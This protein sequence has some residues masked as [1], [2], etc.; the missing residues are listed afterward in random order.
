MCTGARRRTQVDLPLERVRRLTMRSSVCGLVI[1]LTMLPTS[2]ISGVWKCV[3]QDGHVYYLNY[4]NSSMTCTA[5]SKD[6]PA[7]QTTRRSSRHAGTS[8]K[9]EAS[10]ESDRAPIP[11][12]KPTAAYGTGFFV[13]DGTYVATNAHVVDRCMRI[14]V[15][16]QNRVGQ[17]DLVAENATDDLAVLRVTGV[18]GVATSIRQHDARSGESIL[19]AG[20]PLAG[21]LSSELGVSDGIVNTTAGLRGDQSR[22][23][24]SAPV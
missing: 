16:L 23:Q 2:A 1:A 9:Q 4:N 12:E 6:V 3:G 5:L 13:S 24:I 22:L 20:F 15:R 10:R 21:L 14:E 7:P 19:A 11:N 8:Q 17:A 18:K